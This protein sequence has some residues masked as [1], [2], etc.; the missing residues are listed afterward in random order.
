ME[1]V[2]GVIR[3]LSSKEEEAHVKKKVGG[4]GERRGD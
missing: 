4:R 1:V 2:I 3:A